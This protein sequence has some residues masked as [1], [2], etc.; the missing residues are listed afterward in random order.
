MSLIFD[1]MFYALIIFHSCGWITFCVRR[2]NSKDTPT[3][4]TFSTK[5]VST[6]LMLSKT[7]SPSPNST[8]EGK[9]QQ[10]TCELKT[11]SECQ[12]AIE[13]RN[14][15][16]SKKR[17]RRQKSCRTRATDR[18]RTATAASMVNTMMFPRA[19]KG[20]HDEE[21]DEMVTTFIARSLDFTLFKLE[22]ILEEE[23]RILRL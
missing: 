9:T 21:L 17:L 11:K 1:V 4:R 14:Q 8:S 20:N 2:K 7:Q 23:S 10:A 15:V 18:T 22:K 5:S 6:E 19:P 16:E 12:I 13:G 3:K